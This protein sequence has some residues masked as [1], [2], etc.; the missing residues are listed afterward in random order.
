MAAQNIKILK[1]KNILLLFLFIP[2]FKA[3]QGQNLQL[4]KIHKEY[5]LQHSFVFDLVNTSDTTLLYNVSLERQEKNGEWQEVR[6]DVFTCRTTKSARLLDVTAKATK[7]NVFYPGKYIV[8]ADNYFRLRIPYGHD[9]R[10]NEGV[11]F[12]DKFKLKK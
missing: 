4:K 8:P 5:S 12:S 11:I 9:Y 7:K 10:V 3:G 1:L 6:I 2:A